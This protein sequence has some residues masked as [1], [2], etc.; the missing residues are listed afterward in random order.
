V[1]D[2]HFGLWELLFLC[3]QEDSIAQMPLAHSE[4]PLSVYTL[5]EGSCFFLL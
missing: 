4:K 3:V 1:I 5:G 2:L